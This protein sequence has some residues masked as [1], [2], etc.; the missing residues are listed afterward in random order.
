MGALSGAGP[1]HGGA[2]FAAASSTT[3]EDTRAKET[4]RRIPVFFFASF[5]TFVPELGGPPCEP[6]TG[7]WI[8]ACRTQTE[9]PSPVPF[10]A[11]AE[12]EPA[13]FPSQ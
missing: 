10:G 4:P 1:S 11:I 13:E 12:Q 8:Y 5:F 3:P 9:H 7:P 2:S 6:E